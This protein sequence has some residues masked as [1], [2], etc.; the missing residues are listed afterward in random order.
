MSALNSSK[1][2]SKSLRRFKV[3]T[4]KPIKLKRSNNSKNGILSHF[5]KEIMTLE[6]DKNFFTKKKFDLIAQNVRKNFKN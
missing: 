3:I 2:S 5:E 1:L 4:P 6:K